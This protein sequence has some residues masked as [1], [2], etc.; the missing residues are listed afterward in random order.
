VVE[1]GNGSTPI[2]NA[3]CRFVDEDGN[4]YDTDQSDANG[5]YHL[6]VPPGAS[7]YILANP[8]S[9]PSLI[10][11]TAASTIGL[12]I[13]SIK[14]G[15]NI[16]PATTVIADIINREDPT[17]P[18][19]RK[20][21]LLKAIQDQ[22]DPNLTLVVAMA[23]RLYGQMLSRGI[24]SQFG[25]TLD[26]ADDGGGRSDS[27]VDGGA[28]GE[29]GDGADF[30]PLVEATCEF[31]YGDTLSGGEA[32]YSAALGDFLSDGD[33]NRPDLVDFATE[34][35]AGYDTQ[36]LQQAFESV[37]PSGIGIPITTQTDTEG[38][39]RLPTPPGVP[40]FVRCTPKD[41]ENLVLGTYLPSRQ[42]G[43]T[44]ENE[45]V[46]PATT[47]FSALIAPQLQ[48]AD[49]AA[50]KENYL[51]DIAGLDIQVQ[52]GAGD[53]V[54]YFNLRPGT[55]PNNEGVGLV[56]FSATA[57]FNAFNK[58]GLDFDFL[59]AVDD[60]VDKAAETPL[61]PVDATFLRDQG[62]TATQAQSVAAAVN[63]SIEDTS[64][65]LGTNL[66]L[67]LSTGR[68]YVI[69]MDE[70]DQPVQGALVDIENQIECSGCGAAT[71]SDGSL[72]LVLSSLTD[73]AT[74]IVVV[75][76]GVPGYLEARKRVA[77]TP[78]ARVDAVIRLNGASDYSI[79][80]ASG[81]RVNLDGTWEGVCNSDVEDGE[82]DRSVIT[83][84]GASFSVTHR[85]WAYTTNCNG[86][87]DATENFGGSF[88]LGDELAVTI[89]NTGATATRIDVIVTYAT[90]TI[91]SSSYVDE[92]N[93]DRECGYDDWVVGVSKDI[94]GTD[95]GPDPTS[96]D[97]IYIDDTGDRDLFYTGD[98]DRALDGLGYPMVIDPESAA[99]RR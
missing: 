18:E 3:R 20:A 60:L 87:Y 70:N 25:S 71:A 65:Q 89:N 78:S 24:N 33:L 13:G 63:N 64:Q 61:N 55:E 62:L 14:A 6:Y 57:L 19:G 91:N 54:E 79:I 66:N 96:K 10:L 30:S 86:S 48:T 40:G 93:Q 27:D 69:V 49:V 8:P 76:S 67:A 75:V 28:T 97:V 80:G 53:E 45:D 50:A 74:D 72:E 41:R 17:D 22:Q 52:I 5:T 92:V 99:E 95:C 32:C 42:S 46:T 90:G 12:G 23:T 38:R 34:V 88:T 29:A 26:G 85:Y 4:E 37:F 31:V 83:I 9:A 11:S 16:S 21:E 94:L 7:G 39:Y 82:S 59:T 2:R 15:E 35:T 56:A 68:I 44:L 58:N 47:I 77:I 36:T 98:D 51:E 81:N 1:A 73:A 84:T 43:V